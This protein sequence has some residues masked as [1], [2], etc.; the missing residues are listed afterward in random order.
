MPYLLV[1]YFAGYESLVLFGLYFL[2][3][4]VAFIIAFIFKNTLF[5]KIEEPFIIELP[6]YKLPEFKSLIIHTWEK[7]KGFLKKAGT[8]I[9]S[10]SSPSM[11]LIKL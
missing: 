10:I 6:E 1:L 4:I 5:K 2:G 7:G 8:L 9:F 3:L 11:V